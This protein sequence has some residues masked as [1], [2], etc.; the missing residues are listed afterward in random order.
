[1][2]LKKLTWMIKRHPFLYL[3]R[4]KLLSQNVR[5]RDIEYYSY[6]Q[7]NDKIEIPDY[8]NV[9]NDM[10]FKDYQPTTDL[11]LVKHLSTWL[12]K[13]IKGGPG[14]SVPS[15][16]ALRMMLEGKGGVC[17]DLVQ[18]FNNFCVINDIQV[19]E[20]GV[21]RAPFNKDFGGHSFN[22]VF[23][24]ELGKWV[25]ID[26]S[27]GVL[28]Y[29]KEEILLSVI[30]LYTHLRLGKQ[31]KY[32]TYYEDISLNNKSIEQN[33]LHKETVPFFNL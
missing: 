24:K 1:M 2:K 26:V 30:E 20:W 21:T 5:N 12:R 4:F 27:W 11:G 22:E 3:T 6:N 18:V 23:C 19:R 14:L 32:K 33:Y 25:L 7:E 16:N 17:S 13:H 10:I 31:I 9:V 28:F 15:E 8:Y 29:D